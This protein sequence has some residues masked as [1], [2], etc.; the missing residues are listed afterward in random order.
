MRLRSGRMIENKNE[1][2]FEVFESK[3]IRYA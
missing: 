3:E 1:H 2:T